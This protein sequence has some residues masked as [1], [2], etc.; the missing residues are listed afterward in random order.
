MPI[1]LIVPILLKREIALWPALALG[2]TLTMLLYIVTTWALAR[3]SL[4]L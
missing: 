3:T 1:F 2:C 4:R